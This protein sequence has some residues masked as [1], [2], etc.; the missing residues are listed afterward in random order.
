MCFLEAYDR[1]V[2]TP[3][4]D[5]PR[6]TISLSSCTC[7]RRH[8]PLRCLRWRGRTAMPTR[9]RSRTTLQNVRSPDVLFDVLFD[10]L[11]SLPT[12]APNVS[13]PHS[14]VTHSSAYNLC[15]AVR[16][17]L[18]TNNPPLRADR[19]LP[20]CSHKLTRPSSLPP[21]FPLLRSIPH[22][23]LTPLTPL[24]PPNHRPPTALQ[25]AFPLAPLHE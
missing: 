5:Q 15:T 10:V 3:P 7:P 19:L 6:H 13:A 12:L 9:G 18:P 2:L 16:A 23:P 22:R 11:C 17:Y 14:T 24:T 4:S 25:S 1:R 21:P 20:D 8:L